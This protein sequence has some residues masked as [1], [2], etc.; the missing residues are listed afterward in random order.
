MKQSS[1]V[2]ENLRKPIPISKFYQNSYLENK[3][4]SSAYVYMLVFYSFVGCGFCGFIWSKG[5][6]KMD[7]QEKKVQY[8]CFFGRFIV[9]LQTE[10]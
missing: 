10:K 3:S 6:K 4:V 2:G 5:R 7:R 1:P 9:F 8:L